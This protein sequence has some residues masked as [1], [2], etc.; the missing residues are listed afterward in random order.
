MGLYDSLYSS[1]L[2]SASSW[3]SLGAATFTATLR[4]GDNN[5]TPG[6]VTELILNGSSGQLEWGASGTDVDSDIDYP[7][8]PG[9]IY[10]PVD[11]LI[12]ASTS[13]QTPSELTVGNA[14][15]VLYTGGS[16]NTITNVLVEATVASTV[17]PAS[18]KTVAVSWYNLSIVFT[19]SQTN[20]TT[21]P[22]PP[23][24][25]YAYQGTYPPSGM[26]LARKNLPM[27]LP[28]GK[29]KNWPLNQPLL[30]LLATPSTNFAG[31]GPLSVEI[32]GGIQLISNDATYANY[33][34]GL[35]STALQAK[36]LVWT[37]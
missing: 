5:A 32:Q 18:G 16:Y 37:S 26:K 13:P 19:D 3:S 35:A 20:Q 8:P 1:G 22:N 36:I 4:L 23:F 25:P 15:S 17:N 11:L 29:R 9:G 34:S 2:T 14:S 28:P 24:S 33:G 21:N 12:P 7:P 10:C 30:A 31:S 27:M 6:G